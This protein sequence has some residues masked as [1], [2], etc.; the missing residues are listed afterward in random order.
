MH[1]YLIKK[2][3]VTM[4]IHTS[5]TIHTHPSRLVYNLS[6]LFSYMVEEEIQDT[7]G[8]KLFDSFVML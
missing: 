1:K 4:D 8:S 6:I 7:M 3:D 2:E 5:F